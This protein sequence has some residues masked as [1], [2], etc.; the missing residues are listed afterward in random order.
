MKTWWQGAEFP[1]HC[2]PDDPWF[3][4]VE[5]EKSG[6]FVLRARPGAIAPVQ[7]MLC[8]E[9]DTS[10]TALELAW[11]WPVHVPALR[12]VDR[13][14]APFVGECK[15]EAGKPWVIWVLLEIPMEAPAGE[16]GPRTLSGTLV[17]RGGER[18]PIALDVEVAGE[19]VHRGGEDDKDTLARLAW[20]DSA[21]G[22]EE[23]VPQPFLPVTVRERTLGVLGREVVLGEGGVPSAVLTHF[24]GINDVLVDSGEDIF[25]A[26]P[27]LETVIAGKPVQLEG[28]CHIVARTDARVSWEAVLRSDE[29]TCTVRGFLEFDGWSRYTV[30]WQ[31]A[32][33]LAVEDIRLLFRLKHRYARWLTG[34]GT[35]VLERPQSHRW[36]W[37]RAKHQ[38]GFYCGG[39]NGGI[40]VRP[41]AEDYV[42][43]YCNIYYLFG[44]RNMPRAW[45]NEGKGYFALERCDDCVEL[46]YHCGACV[47]PAGQPVRT[48]FEM[49]FTPFKLVNQA[50]HYATRYFQA[51]GNTTPE[52]WLQTAH[53]IGASHVVVHHAKDIYPFI[54]YPLY[55][56]PAM[57]DFAAKAHS[58]GLKMKPYYTVRELT[59]K[60]PE[61]FPL[62]SLRAEVF[63]QPNFN[64]DGVPGQGEKDAWL[65]DECGDHVL[66]AWKHVFTE[67]KY[68]GTTDPAVI[69][70]PASRIVN[71]YVEGLRWMCDNWQID[72]IYVDDTGLD[73]YAF[74]RA[75]RVLDGRRPGAK[76]D[77]H[78]WN[79]FHDEYGESWAHNMVMYAEI[80]P[81]IDSLWFGEGFDFNEITPNE[82]LVECSGLPFGLMSEMLQGGGN[83]WRGLLFGMTNRAGWTTA[84]TQGIWAMREKYGFDRAVLRGWWEENP[85]VSADNPAVYVTAYG[86]P[87]G[88]MAVAASFAEGEVS[89]QL[90]IDAAQVA[91]PKSALL[92]Y[93]QHLQEEVES[94]PD[95][96]YTLQPGG[97]VLVFY[98][99]DK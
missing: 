77:L 45:V 61:F 22:T 32:R 20:L 42:V 17:L 71:F 51:P 92:P 37:D 7:L 64:Y 80:F 40:V 58:Q 88:I 34:V 13:F 28:E 11:E 53:E 16:Q 69:V 86:L 29:L 62:R 6:G 95:A 10:V 85:L 72:G 60:L 15:L 12:G 89:M 46:G 79:Q 24:Q 70:N 19:P 57:H 63:A 36:Q 98:P 4:T 9:Q 48:D 21:L 66:P 39:M 73:R 68:A 74:Q 67:G 3:S 23:T 99:Y 90:R 31:A 93:I 76:I 26:P 83:P 52:S 8:S 94:A 81:Y 59:S 50:S 65:K 25:A 35:N 91:Q 47:L 14:G 2:R 75:R 87:D 43:P 54:N 44:Y 18:L 82:M 33:E 56:A 96:R 30:E 49:G 41:L 38:D 84:G 1:Y 97:G 55:D 27:R 78:S 5:P